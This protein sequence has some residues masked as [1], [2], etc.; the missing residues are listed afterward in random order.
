MAR[1]DIDTPHSQTPRTLYE[2]LEI[3]PDLNDDTDG[4]WR[5]V[6]KFYDSRCD[7]MEA[8]SALG[9]FS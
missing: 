7:D 8:V 4:M 3:L 5:M 2:R 1:H 6:G 9:L